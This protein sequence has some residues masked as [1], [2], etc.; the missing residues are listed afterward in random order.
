MLFPYGQTLTLLTRQLTGRDGDGNA[1]Y[2]NVPTAVL[3]CPVWP[4]TSSELVQ[5]QDT[6]I[7]GLTAILPPGTDASAI[8]AVMVGADKYE[9]DGQ[10][11]AYVSP[12]TNMNPGIEVQLTKVGG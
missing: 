6:V 9:I 8:D 11:G 5:G 1:V 12:F 4:R 2:Q 10:P 3:N 7:I